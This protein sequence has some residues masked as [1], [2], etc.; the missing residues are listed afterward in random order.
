MFGHQLEQVDDVDEPDLHVGQVLPQQRGRGQRLH[1]RQVAATRHH[2]V[3]LGALVVA[4]PIPDAGALCAM[5]DRR[6]HV[7]V[8]QV[9]LLV[10]DDDV[11]VVD[12]AQAVV[13]DRE[14]AVGVGRQIDPH[15]ARTLVRD[16]VE[17][18]RDPGA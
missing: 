17:E 18:A 2:H 9:H 12:A 7:Q 14:Q 1:R 10:G 5:G 4:R 6:L 8:L 3:G 16:H 11:H 15:H 13:G